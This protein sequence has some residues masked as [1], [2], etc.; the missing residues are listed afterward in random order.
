MASPMTHLSG[1]LLVWR[2]AAKMC[3]QENP[4]RATHP[5]SCAV[6]L[7][8]TAARWVAS[9]LARMFVLLGSM[10][11]EPTPLRKGAMSHGLRP[12]GP[13]GV[14]QA[15]FSLGHRCRGRHKDLRATP[16]HRVRQP[17]S[18]GATLSGSRR[19]DTVALTSA[20]QVRHNITHDDSG[21][22]HPERRVSI[23]A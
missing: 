21:K 14:A 23:L 13:T 7:P 22:L 12:L 18:L 11:F 2:Q 17:P 4:T 5:C 15:L 20:P 16:P 19:R 10:Q 6:A 3:L 9:L 1:P 8:L